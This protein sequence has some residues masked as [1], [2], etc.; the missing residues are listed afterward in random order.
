MMSTI[1]AKTGAA[2]TT[3]DWK[4]QASR[5]FSVDTGINCL[6]GVWSHSM[7]IG[8]I[9]V[10]F[11][12]TGVSMGT[13]TASAEPTPTS[14]PS[15]VK[16]ADPHRLE[17]QW[18]RTDGNYVLELSGIAEGGLLKASY[19]NPTPIKVFSA[20]WGRKGGEIGVRVELRDLN[21]PGSTYTLQY[22][23]G[24]DRLK[25]TYFQALEKQTFTVEF[26]R[27]K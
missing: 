2:L 14:K 9:L 26:V 8:L 5:C 22:D 1:C 19:F 11:Y 4:P 23:P 3:A 10:W 13:G 20:K 7:F 27:A 12:I 24:A 15:A 21:Y 6:T 16:P 18:V 25:G 17:G